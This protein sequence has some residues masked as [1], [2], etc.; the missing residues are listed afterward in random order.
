MKK[1]ITMKQL[2]QILKEGTA[3]VDAAP[4]DAAA[5]PADPA[6]APADA[7]PAPAADPMVVDLVKQLAAAVGLQVAD[8]AAPEAPAPE[9]A[10]EA[11]AADAMPAAVAERRARL[12][13]LREARIARRRALRK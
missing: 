3:P 10:P 4:V 12:R 1:S 7:A 13:K 9:A 6:A 11:P 5:A 8:A 2:A